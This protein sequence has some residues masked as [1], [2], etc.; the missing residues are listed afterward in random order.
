VAGRGGAGADDRVGR[1]DRGCPGVKRGAYYYDMYPGDKE[2]SDAYR[3]EWRPR[4]WTLYQ[5]GIVALLAGLGAALAPR[6][7][8]GGQQA[9]R[10]LAACVAFLAAIGEVISAI[11]PWAKRMR[12]RWPVSLRRGG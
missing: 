3:D 10:W 1:V 12:N 8:V 9:L 11:Q 4:L 2:K 7:G 5:A 6:D